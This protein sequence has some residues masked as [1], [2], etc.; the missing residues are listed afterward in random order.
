[1]ALYIENTLQSV[2]CDELNSKLC[3]SIWCKIYVDKSDYFIVGVCYRTQD[4]DEEE[5]NLLFDSIKLACDMNNS[6]LIIGDFNYPDINW[7]S[8]TAHSSGHKF[9]KLI[10]DCYLEQHVKENT[11]MNKILDLLFTSELTVK[12]EIEVLPPIE[13]CDHNILICNIECK[14][15]HVNTKMQLCYNQADNDGMHIFVHKRLSTVNASL[16]TAS[17]LRYALNEIM[18]EAITQFVPRRMST[19]KQKQPL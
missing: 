9:L 11:R 1:V 5:V 12:D 18:Q 14:S 2:E 8:L 7:S 3:E 16:M 13:N 19:Y 17:E 10:A 4:V 6:I 15:N